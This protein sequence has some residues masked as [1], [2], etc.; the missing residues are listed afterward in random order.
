MTTSNAAGPRPQGTN[1]RVDVDLAQDLDEE[2]LK[3]VKK[4]KS[5]KEGYNNAKMYY[6][7]PYKAPDQTEEGALT[8]K[9]NWCPKSVRV[10]KSTDS[11]LK[12][13]RDGSIHGNR[14]RKS[15]TGRA[16]SLAQGANLPQSAE[17]KHSAKVKTTTSSGTLTVYVQKGQFDVKTMNK[18][19]VF[20]II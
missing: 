4:N 7:E 1:F 6:D 15:C 14:L 10:N 9:C 17:E 2:N 8:Y 5:E 13:H 12:T 20:W 3:W 11:N 16:K 18:I 19:L